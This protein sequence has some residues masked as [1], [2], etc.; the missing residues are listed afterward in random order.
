MPPMSSWDRFADWAEA[1]AADPARRKRV[2]IGLIVIG[3]AVLGVFHQRIYNTFAGPFS[4]EAKELADLQDVPFQKLVKVVR[5]GKPVEYFEL[6]RTGASEVEYGRGGSR[7]L[8]TFSILEIDGKSVLVRIED[9][10]HEQVEGVIR[11]IDS[12][13]SPVGRYSAHLM[14][15][16]TMAR[17]RMWSLGLA[18]LGVLAII[19]GLDQLRRA[20]RTPKP[21]SLKIF[22]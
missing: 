22:S 5:N 12:A 17:F 14:L 15:D 6:E 1:V 16:C 19:L 21:K 11:E 2:A 20:T 7:T 4:I 13:E 18:A 9:S 3:L 10:R 8:A